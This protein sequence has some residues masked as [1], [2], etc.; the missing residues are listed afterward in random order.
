ME[1]GELI[2]VLEGATMQSWAG[3]FS[4]DSALIASGAGDKIVR[5]WRV[6]TGE[7]VHTLSGFT[8]WIRS[9]AFSPDGGH[10]AAGAAGGTLRVFDVASGAC[11]QSWQVDLQ[12]DRSAATFIEISGVRYTA[13]GDLFFRSSEGRVFGYRTSD[14]LKWESGKVLLFGRFATSKDGS[15]DAGRDFLSA[16]V[17]VLLQHQIGE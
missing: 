1:S 2:H 15:L 6:D 16:T 3:A 9:L 14:N 17:D 5:I 12:D 10:L 4:P 13:R 7:L 8:R 11:E